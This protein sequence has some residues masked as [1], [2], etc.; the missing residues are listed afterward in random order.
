M[1]Q[2]YSITKLVYFALI[3][4]FI[5]SGCNQEIE[6][7]NGSIHGKILDAGSKVPVEDCEI[8]LAPGN[9][10]ITSDNY[11]S[12]KHSYSTITSTLTDFDGIKSSQTNS[13]TTQYTSYS[14]QGYCLDITTAMKECYS[15][16][17]SYWNFDNTWTWRGIMNGQ[18][19][20]VSCPRLAWE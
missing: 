4:A 16:Y 18:E 6:S 17:A 13:Y 12:I 10:I 11:T 1:K 14:S 19:V 7:G 8:I 3:C 5:A 9:S 15:D 2:I 20:S